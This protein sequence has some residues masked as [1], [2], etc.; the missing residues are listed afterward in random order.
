MRGG[1]H[2]RILWF[3]AQD[4]IVLERLRRSVDDIFMPQPNKMS[5]LQGRATHRLCQFLEFARGARASV[6]IITHISILLFANPKGIASHSPGL[7]S[8]RG[9]PGLQTATFSTLK[10]LRRLTASDV[11]SFLH[12][13][14]KTQ[15][16]GVVTCNKPPPRVVAL[17]QP[18]A[19]RR[20]P[21]GIKNF[22]IKDVGNNKGFSPLPRVWS[23]GCG[24]KR[25]AR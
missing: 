14:T 6:L 21:F 4:Y 18:W 16:V 23:E 1:A 19:L 17:R 24:V 7:P 20:N 3:V 5:K 11:A 9:Y 2:D 22:I 10:G 15:P 12:A 8:L 13:R 25:R